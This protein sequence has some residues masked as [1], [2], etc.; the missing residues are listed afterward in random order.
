MQADQANATQADAAQFKASNAYRYYVVWLLFAVYVLNF[1]DRQILSILNE[2]LKAEFNLSDTEL[3][4]LGGFA[5]AVL[6]STLG[7][8]IARWADRGNRVTIISLAILIWSAFTAVT[9]YAKVT[10]HLVVARIGVGIGEAGCSP[11]AY[12]IISDYFDQKRRA[13]ALSIYS[14]GVYGGSFVG[15]F[16]GGMIAEEYGWRV[17]FLVC[18]IPGIILALIVKLTLREPPRGFSDPPGTIKAPAPP[19]M[20]VMRDLWAKRSFRWLSIGAAMHT[21]AAYGVG[22]FYAS[23]LVRSHGLGLSEVGQVLG[24]I[25]AIGGLGGTFLGGYLSD[26]YVNRTGDIR[27]YLWVPALL[28][29][30]NIPVGQMVYAMSERNAVLVTMVFYIALSASY[31]APNIAITHRLVTVR[32]R[33]LASAVFLLIINLIGMG[34]GPPLAGLLS[35]ILKAYF[36]DQGS[37]IRLATADGLRWSLRILILVNIFAIWFY[38]LG[39]KKVREEAAA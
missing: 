28:L 37:D 38:M 15:L 24:I 30:I 34:F 12:S 39:A 21:F 35:D 27:Y 26:R 31:L 9:A 4:I 20:K 25:V 29:L 36:V 13:T 16:I 22:H 11:P 1:V 19:A 2:E 8:P 33:A 23:F 5:F 10:W 6:Y 14:M 18:G 3:G 32:E 17:A 7:I